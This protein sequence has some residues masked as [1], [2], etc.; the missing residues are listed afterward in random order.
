MTVTLDQLLAL[1]APTGVEALDYADILAQGIV[2]MRGEAPLWSGSQ[3]TILYKDLVYTSY[4]NFLT[5][6]RFN[7]NILRSLLATS[8]GT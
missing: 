6:Q 3:D 2:F 1:A 4:Q 7:L 8:T 5:R